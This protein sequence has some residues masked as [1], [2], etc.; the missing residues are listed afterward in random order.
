MK[1]SKQLG[2]FLGIKDSLIQIIVEIQ[3]DSET[4]SSGNA[5]YPDND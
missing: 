4:A 1:Y 5:P 3:I 2:N